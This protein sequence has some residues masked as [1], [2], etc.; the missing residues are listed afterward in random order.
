MPQ[1]LECPR[2]LV[3]VLEQKTVEVGAAEDLLGDA[4]VTA[5]GVEHAFVIAAADVNAEGDPAVAGDDR[6]IQLD[7][8]VE[9]LVRFA[10]ALTIALAD[11][12]VEEARILRRIDLDVLAPETNQLGDLAAGGVPPGGDGS[13]AGAGGGAGLVGGG[14]RGAPVW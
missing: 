10:A 13:R 1:R 6:V 9:H 5:R 2:P 8:R 3:V 14:M 4:V 11:C 7:G 12:L